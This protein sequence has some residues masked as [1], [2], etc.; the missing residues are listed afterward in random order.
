MTGYHFAVVLHSVFIEP[1]ILCD[2]VW[3]DKDVRDIVKT[4]NYEHKSCYGV[5][6]NDALY[7]IFVFFLS[8]NKK[9]YPLAHGVAVNIFL[10]QEGNVWGSNNGQARS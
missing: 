3:K 6:I 4:L 9:N 10:S 5:F 8:T 2:V 7:A 1:I